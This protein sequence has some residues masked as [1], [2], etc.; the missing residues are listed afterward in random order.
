MHEPLTQDQLTSFRANGYLH[1]PGLIPA[2]ELEAVQKDTLELI[3]KGIDAEF[4]EP[5]F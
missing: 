1:I 3:E 4:D 5:T 2:D